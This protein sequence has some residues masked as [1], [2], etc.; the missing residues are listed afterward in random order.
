MMGELE[1]AN[2][3]ISSLSEHGV[4]IALDDFGTGYSTL[5]HLQRLRAD[6]LKIDRSFV[7]RGGSESRNREIV[8]AVTAMAHALGMAVIGEG[9]ETEAELRGLV[10]AGADNGQGYLLAAPLPAEEIAAF[11]TANQAGRAAA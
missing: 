3:V 6:V 4:L 2:N 7:K 9:V 1:D 8:G 5:E 10:D 11:W